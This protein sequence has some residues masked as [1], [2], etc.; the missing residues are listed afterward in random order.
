[1]HLS[2]RQVQHNQC[3]HLAIIASKYDW[4]GPRTGLSWNETGSHG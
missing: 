3:R 4:P 2:S 1:V